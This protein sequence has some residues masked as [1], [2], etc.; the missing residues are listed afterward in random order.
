MYSEVSCENAAPYEIDRYVVPNAHGLCFLYGIRLGNEH[1]R[2]DS[3]ISLV[4]DI[5]GSVYRLD[6][7]D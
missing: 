5:R 6:N 7:V 2:I 1:N 4:S 3:F